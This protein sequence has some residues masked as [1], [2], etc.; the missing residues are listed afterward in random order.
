M[1]SER[2]TGF[3]KGFSDQIIWTSSYYLTYYYLTSYWLCVIS[4]KWGSVNSKCHFLSY[5]DYFV[6]CFW[7]VCILGVFPYIKTNQGLTE[8][9]HAN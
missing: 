9:N 2:H 3:Y 6:L 5:F 1:H 4:N 8:I 7:V